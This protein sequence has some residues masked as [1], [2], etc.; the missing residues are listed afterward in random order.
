MVGGGGG[1]WVLRAFVLHQQPHLFNATKVHQLDLFNPAWFGSVWHVS[2]WAK[3]CSTRVARSCNMN[4]HECFS[5]PLQPAALNKKPGRKKDKPYTSEIAKEGDKRCVKCNR[6]GHYAKTCREPDISVICANNN[7][8]TAREVERCVVV[9]P[10]SFCAMSY[11]VS[12][13]DRRILGSNLT[14]IEVD[15]DV[16]D[17]SA[18]IYTVSDSE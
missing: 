4:A 12:F 14:P 8:A 6:T 9:A 13:F 11:T 17:D 3:Q 16:P 18:N 10:F 5:S 2:T 15:V 1:V 7:V